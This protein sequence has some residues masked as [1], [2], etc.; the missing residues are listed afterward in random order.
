[1]KDG[2]P[3]RWSEGGG[4]PGA[5][6]LVRSIERTPVVPPDL[7]GSIERRLSR[8]PAPHR[9]R[10]I[11]AATATAVVV[12]ALVLWVLPRAVEQPLPADVEPPRTDEVVQPVEPAG[13]Q[14][15]EV[16]PVASAQVVEPE[17]ALAPPS[18]APETPRRVRVPAPQ[19]D[20]LAPIELPPAPAAQG[21]VLMLLTMPW[22]RV[23]LDGEDTGLDTP[24]R[25]L[26]V[27]AG[28]HVVGFR[29]SDGT[30]TETTV[31]VREGET[32]RLVRQ[33]P[34]TPSHHSV[35]LDPFVSP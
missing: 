23:L 9:T 4:P 3:I 19:T 24:V 12:G 7:R 5:L 25:S 10:T 16:E 21:G 14:P 20:P 17:P 31:E 8:G 32:V 2:D 26:P 30:L 15:E 22:A 35:P 28:R 6:E 11:G 1:M 29:T 34:V 18:R 33:L 13:A 27:S